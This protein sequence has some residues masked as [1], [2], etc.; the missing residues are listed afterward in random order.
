[1]NL[2]ETISFIY[3]HEYSPEMISAKYL[4]EFL[5]MNGISVKCLREFWKDLWEVNSIKL[6]L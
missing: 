5:K 2:S 1:M 4:P 6:S 3:D